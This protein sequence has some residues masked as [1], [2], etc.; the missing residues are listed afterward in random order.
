MNPSL[1]LY[2]SGYHYKIIHNNCKYIHLCIYMWTASPLKG[3]GLLWSYSALSM[4]HTKTANHSGVLLY[5]QLLWYKYETSTTLKIYMWLQTVFCWMGFSVP[6]KCRVSHQKPYMQGQLHDP[7]NEKKIHNMMDVIELTHSKSL[8]TPC[9]ENLPEVHHVGLQIM[10]TKF[11]FTNNLPVCIRK[12]TDWQND[13]QNDPCGW[14]GLKT[15]LPWSQ[16]LIQTFTNTTQYINI[17][18][19]IICW[20]IFLD[21]LYFKKSCLFFCKCSN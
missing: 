15:G 2:L 13:T 16:C 5:H 9:I 18:A 17:K 11:C 10:F 21:T 19:Y 12:L 6:G 7:I 20:C 3:F 1:P 4:E 14:Q 8:L